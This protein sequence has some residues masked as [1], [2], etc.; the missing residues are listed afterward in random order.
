MY[1]RFFQTRTA[2]SRVG[3]SM[4][5]A[6]AV[7]LIVS[8][9][10]AVLCLVF[11]GAG[12]GAAGPAHLFFG[13]LFAIVFWIPPEESARAV[14][15]N[16]VHVLMFAWYSLY[17][18]VLSVGRWHRRGH[19]TLAAL[20]V[21]HYSGVLLCAY[22]T[23]WGGWDKLAMIS[24]MYGSWITILLVE[25]LV[26]VHL[27]AFQYARSPIPYRPRLSWPALSALVAGLVGGVLLLNM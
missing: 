11:A 2:E 19:V 13:P 25:T 26:M 23:R 1:G 7:G 20:L 17:G 6:A 10:S 16:S 24:R 21:F 9:C 18:A 14:V 5:L 15:L 22:S 27:L 3:R 8:S 4:V 12:H